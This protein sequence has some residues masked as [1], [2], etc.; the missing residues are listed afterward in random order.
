M[1]DLNDDLLHSPYD[2]EFKALA[3]DFGQLLRKIVVLPGKASV[4]FEKGGHV[5]HS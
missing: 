1:R 4:G 3:R 2:E 5:G